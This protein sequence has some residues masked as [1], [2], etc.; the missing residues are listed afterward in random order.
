VIGAHGA[1]LATGHAGSAAGGGESP[2]VRASNYLP[3]PLCAR[4]SKRVRQTGAG[5]RRDEALAALGERCAVSNRK[6]AAL[7][8]VERTI[9]AQMERS[10]DSLFA[11]RDA[12]AR[13]REPDHRTMEL[14]GTIER[15]GPT[16][17]M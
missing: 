16:R 15:S 10:S 9:G 13:E 8:L 3:G 11:V 12:P 14:A 4:P 5:P 17:S 1:T 2:K 6:V 7:S